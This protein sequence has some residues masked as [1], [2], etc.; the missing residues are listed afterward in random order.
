MSWELDG[1]VATLLMVQNTWQLHLLSQTNGSILLDPPNFGP[2]R[3]IRSNHCVNKMVQLKKDKQN[4][5][6]IHYQDSQH[7]KVLYAQDI[8]KKKKK[9]KDGAGHTLKFHG[10]Q[11]IISMVNK[12]QAESSCMNSSI[13]QT[14]KII[15]WN[16]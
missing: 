2:G 5:F 4:R 1:T 8:Q 11:S 6:L 10:A 16:M 13:I 7:I 12:E 14:W 3:G 15:N 9:R